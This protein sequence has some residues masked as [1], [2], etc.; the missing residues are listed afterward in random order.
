MGFNWLPTKPIQD[1]RQF[2]RGGGRERERERDRETE[3]RYAQIKT[4]MQL[5][6]KMLDLTSIPLL[7]HLRHQAINSTLQRRYSLWLSVQSSITHSVRVPGG[8]AYRQVNCWY[9]LSSNWL[10]TKLE[11]ST[12]PFYSGEPHTN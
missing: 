12:K 3:R 8:A 10:P 1:T 2:Y 5:T 4:Y 7:G 9:F 11:C 6:Q